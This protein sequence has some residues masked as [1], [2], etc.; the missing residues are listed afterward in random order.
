[1][2]KY[3]LHILFVFVMANFSLNS[4]QTFEDFQEFLTF[5]PRDEGMLYEEKAINFI[6][7]MADELKLPVQ[8][9]SVSP[10]NNQAFSYSQN[11]EI[12]LSGSTENE[13]LY[14]VPL[15][16]SNASLLPVLLIMQ[17]LGKLDQSPV[18]GARFVFLGA[19][20]GDHDAYPMG[21]KSFLQTYSP[22][23]KALFFY[24]DFDYPTDRPYL[25]VTNSMPPALWPLQQAKELLHTENIKAKI[26]PLSSII[27]RIGF[28][29]ERII[30]LYFSEGLTG[31]HMTAP[32]KK[33]KNDG[34][35]SLEIWSQSIKNAFVNWHLNLTDIN[36]NA[37]KNYVNI[38]NL[39][40]PEPIY[41]F[42]LIIS[43]TVL[44]SIFYTSKKSF[45]LSYQYFWKHRRDFSLLFIIAFLSFFLSGLILLSLLVLQNNWELWH[46][47]PLHFFFYKALL[48]FLLY[49]VFLQFLR[50][51][52]LFAIQKSSIRIALLFSIN[53]A[54]ILLFINITFLWPILWSIFC[55]LIALSFS[56]SN[57]K[58]YAFLLSP[59]FICL[60]LYPIFSTSL[61]FLSGFFLFDDLFANF[62][63]T[64]IFFPTI[65]TILSLR[66]KNPYL[67]LRK[68]CGLTLVS[69]ILFILVTYSVSNHYFY[70]KNGQ[71]LNIKLVENLNLNSAYIDLSSP[72]EIGSF[73]LSFYGQKYFI[74]TPL[75]YFQ[76]NTSVHHSLDITY[77]ITEFY[78][79]NLLQISIFSPKTINSYDI[80]ISSREDLFITNSN[81]PTQAIKK[82]GVL[83][84]FS[85]LTGKNPPN[86]LTIN[87]ITNKGREIIIR[88][89]ANIDNN[90][91]AALIIPDR[92][93]AVA[94]VE[95][96]KE[97][98]IEGKSF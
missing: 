82:E 39:L 55:L 16:Q 68:N 2:A 92:F 31:I 88:T 7:A 33:S 48:F 42:I 45:F 32:I 52:N 85:V 46:Q 67:I 69:A 43:W 28:T 54:V 80:N 73:S 18:I 25:W 93:K 14:L 20:F 50:D 76:L 86:P 8:I 5:L 83:S 19:E 77:K 34:S 94:S 84:N 47:N 63:L 21:S 95:I 6:R 41:I 89:T 17:E 44:T 22:N 56:R 81:F 72:Y 12:V 61:S 35:L 49:F 37:E 71:P 57:I 3:I 75:R 26:S 90:E 9:Y 91:E 64:M 79:T 58:I 36:V 1:M 53:N 98:K 13:I 10:S 65:L 62:I 11:V 27:T 29:S 23:K 60:E 30:P 87:L 40:I 66:F 4:E 74:K 78:E 70:Q 96:T 15:N 24:F 97:I 51:I 59:I 38:G